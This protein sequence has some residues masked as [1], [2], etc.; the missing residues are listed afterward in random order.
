ML[1]TD[2]AARGKQVNH[3]FA[4]DLVSRDGSSALRE[5]KL[6]IRRPGVAV[7]MIPAR[8]L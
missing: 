6:R 5:G 4:G 2:A 3:A 7:M 8:R 1:P